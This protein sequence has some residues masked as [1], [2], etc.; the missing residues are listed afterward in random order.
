MYLLPCETPCC[1][2]GT[3]RKGCCPCPPDSDW[4]AGETHVKDTRMEDKVEVW[5]GHC[6]S[7]KEE[8]FLQ[9]EGQMVVLQANEADPV[10]YTND[11]SQRDRLY[12]A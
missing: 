7:P 12:G 5:T 2:L 3:K 6:R 1:V 4:Q 8:G 10:S 9:G 11:R